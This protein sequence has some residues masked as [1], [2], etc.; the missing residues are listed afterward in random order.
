LNQVL[1][2]NV[3]IGLFTSTPSRDNRQNLTIEVKDSLYQREQVQFG[4]ASDGMA[5]NITPVNFGRVLNS[6]GTITHFG[7][8]DRKLN[9][10][11]LIF[12]ELTPAQIVVKNQFIYFN[13]GSLTVNFRI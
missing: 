6:W 12:D 1:Q 2:S 4:S 9:G 11:L 5:S 3:Y 13:T 7:I 8:F 10:N